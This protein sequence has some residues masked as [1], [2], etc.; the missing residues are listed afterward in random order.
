MHF[1]RIGDV[2]EEIPVALI[3]DQPVRPETDH[4]PTSTARSSRTTPSAR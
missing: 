1:G 2:G 3:D 4:A